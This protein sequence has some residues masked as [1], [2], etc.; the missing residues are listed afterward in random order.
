MELVKFLA[1]KTS[2]EAIKKV[3]GKVAQLEVEILDYKK[4]IAAAVKAA[5]SAAIRPTRPRNRATHF[6]K[7]SQS[8]RIRWQKSSEEQKEPSSWEKE[9]G[10]IS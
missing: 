6:S 8:L 9:F 2:F 1:I 4:Q 7:V 5:T 10:L 3:T